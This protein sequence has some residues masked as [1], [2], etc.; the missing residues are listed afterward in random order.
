MFVAGL[1]GIV[2]SSTGTSI[3]PP[4]LHT[5][6]PR[7]FGAG[8]V[9]LAR[10]VKD[11]CLSKVAWARVEFGW[12]LMASELTNAEPR[13]NAVSPTLGPSTGRRDFCKSCLL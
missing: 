8:L 3:V 7:A 4:F 6:A 2:G 9:C 13:L 1:A 12:E 10:D 11:E 5:H